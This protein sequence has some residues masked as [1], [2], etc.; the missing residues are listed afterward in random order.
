MSDIFREVEEEFRREKILGYFR[1]YG[2][3]VIAA[4]VVVLAVVGAYALWDRFDRRARTQASDSY[5][6]AI[7]LVQSSQPDEALSALEALSRDSASGYRVLAL[8][9]K[10]GILIESGDYE[11]A[12]EIYD[13]IAADGA[14]DSRL[15]DLARIKAALIMIDSSSLED[16]RGRVGSLVDTGGPWRFSAREAMALAAFNEGRLEQARTEFQLLAFDPSTPIN[17]R[18]R[19]REMLAIIGTPQGGLGD[20]EPRTSEDMSSSGS[21]TVA[22]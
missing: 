15:K 16:I 9:A 13:R 7:E 2:V 12:A 19:A 20:L 3:Y 18:S 5:R 14:A 11:E 4:A 21:E 17:L 10:A 1:Q 22:D 6:A 8:F